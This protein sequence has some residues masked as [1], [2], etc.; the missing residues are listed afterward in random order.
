MLEPQVEAQRERGRAREAHLTGQL[1]GQDWGEVAEAVV[2]D[3]RCATVGPGGVAPEKHVAVREPG[4]EGAGDAEPVDWDQQA[5]PQRAATAEARDGELFV[6][7]WLG[8]QRV[9]LGALLAVEVRGGL[10]DV[11]AP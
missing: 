7:G 4:T 11:G 9:D 2:A 5:Q 8:D 10:G 3:F 6:A 1:E